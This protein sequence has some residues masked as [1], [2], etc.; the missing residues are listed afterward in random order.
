MERLIITAV[1]D[2]ILS[3]DPRGRKI[4]MEQRKYACFIVTVKGRIRFTLGDRTLICDRE[5]PVFLPQG[6]SYINECLETAE[7]YVFNFLTLGEH[8]PESLSTPCEPQVKRAFE[9]IS[10][11]HS[12]SV[13]DEAQSLGEL[14]LLMAELC[15]AP[16]VSTADGILQTACD[17][18]SGAL[19]YV[20]VRE[21]RGSE[22]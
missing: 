18:N 1:A 9:Q 12:V 21:L 13:A 8:A 5:H 15:A 14:Y 7:S 3:K 10:A 20:E 11:G 6:A 4:E 19:G 2:C 16:S 17:R 22:L